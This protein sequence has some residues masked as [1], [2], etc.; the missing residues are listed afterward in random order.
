[1][2]TNEPSKT[3]DVAVIGSG[4]AG[5]TAALYAAR[6][7]LSVALFER[8]APGGQL[9]ETEK[10]E[11]YPGF[12]EG[13]G[14]FDLA[15]SMKQQAD[16][17][18]VVPFDE[19][20]TAVDFSTDPCTLTTPFSTVCAVSVIVATGARPRKMDLPNN[21]ELEGRGI[22]YCATCDGNFFRGK[23]VVV[24][25]GGNTAAADAIYLSRI[26]EEVTVVYRRDTLRATHVYHAMLEGLENVRFEWDSLVTEAYAEEGKL[27]GVKVENVKTK[28]TK[29]LACEGMFVA[30]GTIPNTEFLAGALAL[31]EHGYIVAGEDGKTSVPGVFAAG[32]VRTKA[33]RQVATAVGDGANVAEEAAEFVAAHR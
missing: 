13:I 31:D 14:G 12:P 4:P 33:L 15:F 28:E 27:S 16:R 3:F 17:F 7:G 21:A 1:M 10:I 25:G 11:N 22:S 26:C 30:I 2:N 9:A 32:D 24:I 19:E 29:D 6:A 23:K 5:M 8:M 20:V 18:G